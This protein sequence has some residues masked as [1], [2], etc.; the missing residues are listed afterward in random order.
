MPTEQA[1][2]TAETASE[3]VNGSQAVEHTAAPETT[4]EQVQSPQVDPSEVERL[5]VE[6]NQ[7]RMRENQLINQRKDEERKAA[8]EAGRYKELYEQQL[9]D[10]EAEDA[11]KAEA[12]RI[13]EAKS[14]RDSVIASYEN[15]KVKELARTLVEDDPSALFWTGEADVAQA[16]EQV[17]AR[18]DRLG[19]KLG[20]NVAET[21][22][23]PAVP[24][25][26]NNP[27]AG[28]NPQ[29][30]SVDMKALEDRLKDYEF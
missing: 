9:A 13:N 23:A 22:T 28:V 1:T 29:P 30:G 19:E 7:A 5:R 21:E 8:E 3:Q 24:T 2:A 11:A 12:D 15:E 20:L 10:K 4:Q 18:L 27:M 14:L 16:K 26:P 6:L 25:N 17:K